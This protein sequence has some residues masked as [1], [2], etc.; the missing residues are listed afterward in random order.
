[1]GRDDCYLLSIPSSYPAQGSPAWRGLG[2]VCLGGLSL[3]GLG[4]LHGIAHTW[5]ETLSTGTLQV[6]VGSYSFGPSWL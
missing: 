6:S 5:V 1:M 2:K 4:L 3:L